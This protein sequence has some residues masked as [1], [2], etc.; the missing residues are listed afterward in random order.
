MSVLV[1]TLAVA[2]FN[3]SKDPIARNFAYLYAV[4]SVGIMVRVLSNDL[5]RGKKRLKF[6]KTTISLNLSSVHPF[7]GPSSFLLVLWVCPVSASH[8]H[9]PQ[10]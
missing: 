8:H 3:A 4:I 10:T 5:V 2:L 7:I 1:G 9:D 6:F